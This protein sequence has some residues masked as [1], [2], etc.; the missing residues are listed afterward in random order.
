MARQWVSPE[1]MLSKYYNDPVH[2]VVLSWKG[3]GW[4]F[5]EKEV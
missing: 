5:V 2:P 3:K 4:T 1:R